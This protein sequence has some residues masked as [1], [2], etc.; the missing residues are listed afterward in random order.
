[1]DRLRL[2]VCLVLSENR[3]GWVSEYMCWFSLVC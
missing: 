3:K 2:W 1:M